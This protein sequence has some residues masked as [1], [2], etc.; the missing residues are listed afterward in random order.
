V[1]ELTGVRLEEIRGR[2]RNGAVVKARRVAV[3]AWRR[4][5]RSLVEMSAAISISRPAA[6]L[7]I[8]RLDTSDRDI[9]ILVRR[10]VYTLTASEK[11]GAS[12]G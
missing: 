10:I 5:E 7:L 4:L 2:N 11:L 6:T 12:L 8:K 1:T 3:L 9:E